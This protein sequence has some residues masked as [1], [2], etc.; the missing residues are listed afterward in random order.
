MITPAELAQQKEKILRQ[1]AS[2]SSLL[3]CAAIPQ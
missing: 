1:Q 3:D 2:V